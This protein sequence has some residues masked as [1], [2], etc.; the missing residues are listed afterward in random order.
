MSNR[1]TLGVWWT[2]GLLAGVAVN[3]SA[4]AADLQFLAGATTPGSDP[5]PFSQAVRA[6]DTLYVSGT[7]G[8]D[9]RTAQAYADPE[10]EAHAVIESV[11]ATLK[12]AGYTLDDLV[13]VT[14]YCTDLSLYAKFNTIYRSYFHG[15]FPARAF[16]GVAAL[17]RNARF[18]IQAV[19]VKGAGG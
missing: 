12:A 8:T 5:P 15:H 4:G 11:Q 9:P 19:A 1:K 18:E 16:I 6:G 17:V 13:S 14:V 10:Q 7:L 3:A 2:L